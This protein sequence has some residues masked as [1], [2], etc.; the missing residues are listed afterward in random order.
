M[1]TISPSLASRLRYLMLRSVQTAER[2]VR[3]A[4]HG[5][6]AEERR[7]REWLLEQ[8]DLLAELEDLLAQVQRRPLELP[9]GLRCDGLMTGP[10]G[11]LVQFTELDSS[12]A[13]HAGSF[14]VPLTEVLVTSAAVSE[15]RVAQKREFARNSG[16][17]S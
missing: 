16:D 17:R 6:L 13:S 11:A 5:P 12:A 2:E 8:R 1:I 3:Q 14:C 7:E 15:R 9:G 10:G 4:V